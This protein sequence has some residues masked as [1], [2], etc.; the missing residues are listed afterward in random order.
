MSGDETS[1]NR[2]RRR[3]AINSLVNIA[4]FTGRVAD[5]TVENQLLIA[6]NLKKKATAM[7]RREIQMNYA[8]KKDFVKC[9]M[10][11]DVMKNAKT[12]SKRGVSKND[13][14]NY[15]TNGIMSAKENLNSGRT[16]IVYIKSSYVGFFVMKLINM[17]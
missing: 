1:T 6:R 15:K 2:Q 9:S 13:S 3:A 11:E 7:M 14:G 4:R 16:V 10:S 17:S 12:D 5:E 8:N